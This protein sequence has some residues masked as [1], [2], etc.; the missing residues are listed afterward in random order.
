MPDFV[1]EFLPTPKMLFRFSAVTFN[2]HLI[3]LDKQYATEVEGYPGKSSSRIFVPPPS[4]LV[5]TE[6]LVHAPLTAL[7][8]LEVTSMQQ[9]AVPFK[10]FEYRARNPLF[11]N[12]P[13]LIK[14]TWEGHC[15]VQLWA[16]SATSG[17]IGMTGKLITYGY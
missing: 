13:V 4:K 7:M 17:V 8:M 10:Y 1:F 5:S 11:V 3:H 14:G 15:I 12:E 16:E 9:P 6:R 2:A